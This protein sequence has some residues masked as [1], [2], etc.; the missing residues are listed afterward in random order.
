MEQNNP[1]L[2][3]Y[4]Q[5]REVPIEAQKSF[6]NGRFSGTDINPMWR[7]KRLTEVLGP[8]GIG[9]Y[10]GKPTF[11]VET[12]NGVKTVHC[13]VE[14]FYKLDNGMWSQPV[15][16]VG[17]N[18]LCTA[19][20]V[21]TDEAYKMAYTDAQSNAAK[22]LGVGADIWFSKDIDKNSRNFEGKYGREQQ[23][24]YYQPVQHVA[25]TQLNIPEGKPI[26]KFDIKNAVDNFFESLDKAGRNNAIAFYEKAAFTNKR[27]NAWGA[28]EYELVVA[29]L[30]TNKRININTGEVLKSA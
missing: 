22:L 25:P 7:I 12:D 29:N 17:G 16:G 23:N 6:S 19:K 21:V 10:F 9:W 11:V 30:I 14:L 24:Q 27:Y 4:N 3:L 8:C 26:Y 15:I 1:N 18:T 28:H 5:F 2:E 20:G 13:I